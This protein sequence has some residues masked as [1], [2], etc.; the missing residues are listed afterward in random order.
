MKKAVLYCTCCDTLNAVLPPEKIK[1]ALLSRPLRV[2]PPQTE[3]GFQST[4]GQAMT[5][6]A[7][8]MDIF[9]P[10]SRLCRCEEA[11]AALDAAKNAGA[12]GIVAAGCSLSAR[13]REAV[14]LLSGHL[15]IQWV[16]IRE[17]CAWLHAASP[18]A[19][20]EKAVDML[21]ME[22]AVLEHHSATQDPPVLSPSLPSTALV[23]GAGPAGLACAATLARMG[24]ETL[25]AER[26]SAPGGMLP[27]LDQLFPYLTSGPKLLEDLVREL[28]ESG[29]SLETATT[30]TAIHPAERGYIAN[31]R[32]KDKE[33]EVTVSAVILAPGAMPFLPK[34]YFKYGELQGVTSQMELETQLGKVERGEVPADTLPRQAVFVQCVG[35]RDNANP[36]CSAICC[37]T[38]LKNALRLRTLV[39]DGSVTVAH[40]NIVTP[41]IHLENL[42]RRATAAGVILR[43]FDPAFTPEPVGEHSLE[44]LRL[45]DALDGKTLVLAADRLVCSTPLRPAPGTAAL[46]NSLGLRLDDAGFACGRE[47]ILPLAPHL[48]GVYLC[49]SVRWPATIEQSL[50]QGRAA[51]IRAA[52]FLQTATSTAEHLSPGLPWTVRELLAFGPDEHHAARIRESA[53]S[54]CGR[55]AAVCP[56]GALILPE[57][58]PMQAIAS[59]CGQCGS[60]AAVCPSG[61]ANLPGK[62]M[63]AMRSRIR[64]ALG[65][66]A[67]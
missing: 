28:T 56:Y 34:G 16:D 55:C 58:G 13:G 4:R 40:R 27:Q 29:A 15:P 51:A 65:G 43:S 57:S 59:R 66:K 20:Q 48:A 6:P 33:R 19:A 45:R 25:V 5:G 21:R 47:P 37:P 14:S 10:C 23:V 54:R 8:A 60:C 49:G 52:A 63:G 46:V 64:E 9:V 39:P 53:C 36:H 17:G 61:A 35:A 11:K 67:I 1:A 22:L 26:R 44:G 3:T 18:K 7:R 24:V 30:V 31:L 2:A 42:Y 12:E 50:E 62:A 38:A 32:G 41:G